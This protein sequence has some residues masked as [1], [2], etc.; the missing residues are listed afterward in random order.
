VSAHEKTAEVV[1]VEEQEIVLPLSVREA[2]EAVRAVEGENYATGVAP[3]TEEVFD[4]IQ[5]AESRN[6]GSATVVAYSVY[7]K[8]EEKRLLS[9]M[10]VEA[11]HALLTRRYPTRWWEQEPEVILEDLA[12]EFGF[13]LDAGGINRVRA[14]H[15]ICAAPVGE[16]PYYYD[17]ESFRFLTLCLSGRAV[18]AD[19]DL[20]PSPHEMSVA[21]H[22]LQFVRPGAL[23]AEVLGFIA[24]AC[25]YQDLWAPPGILAPSQ[26]FV[27]EMCKNLGI[28]VDQERI[29]KVL[30]LAHEERESGGT[31]IPDLVRDENDVQALAVI[32]L[33]NGVAAA[34]ERGE[35]IEDAV[36]AAWEGGTK[37]V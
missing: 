37:N 28:P 10:P 24:A 17:P 18:R 23:E 11:L 9:K 26:P 30:A 34:L 12:N 33:E 1:E 13:I 4:T 14:L 7:S 5:T 6:E 35:E 29:D 3:V 16:S 2:L 22:S 20:Y 27:V 36:I 21:L 8:S 15:A 19:T 25:Y 31:A 32:D